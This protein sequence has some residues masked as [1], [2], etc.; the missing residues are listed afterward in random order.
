[1]PANPATTAIPAILSIAILRSFERFMQ[2]ASGLE[3]REVVT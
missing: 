2:K 3:V 1:M